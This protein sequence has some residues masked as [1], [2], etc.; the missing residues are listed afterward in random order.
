MMEHPGCGEMVDDRYC[1]YCIWHDEECMVWE[2]NY[3]SRDQ[4]R[5]AIKAGLNLGELIK[6]V[7]HGSC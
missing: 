6:E 7:Q 5:K 4:L 2:C 1:P 3:I